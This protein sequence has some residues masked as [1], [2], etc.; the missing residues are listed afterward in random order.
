M[1]GRGWVRSFEA[2]RNSPVN[3]FV[4]VNRRPSI[5]VFSPYSKRIKLVSY[6]NR[7]YISFFLVIGFSWFQMSF[8]VVLLGN[9]FLPPLRPPMLVIWE[10][11]DVITARLKITGNL[12]KRWRWRVLNVQDIFDFPEIL[13]AI[14][15]EPQPKSQNR[16]FD[17]KVP[18]G[19][20]FWYIFV[21]DYLFQLLESPD[22][23]WDAEVKLVPSAFSLTLILSK[24]ESRFRFD[25]H[26][27]ELG[28]LQFTCGNMIYAEASTGSYT[29]KGMQ[30]LF[31][32]SCDEWLTLRLITSRRHPVCI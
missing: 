32:T 5:L 2:T 1:P 11:L 22:E 6:S 21:K 13:Q 19:E 23:T 16:H 7:R 8:Q 3:F 17:G 26:D 29:A 18:S 15:C 25:R 27:G 14:I 31:E 12:T 20:C 28:W 4:L 10:L 24:T 30:P 9:Y